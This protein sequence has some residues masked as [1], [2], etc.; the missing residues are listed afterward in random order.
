MCFENRVYQMENMRKTEESRMR[1]QKKRIAINQN[2]Q[3]CWGSRF[4]VEGKKISFEHARFTMSLSKADLRTPC[5]TQP[6]PLVIRTLR[7]EGSQQMFPASSPQFLHPP[8]F[9]FL[10]SSILELRVCT[11]ALDKA[12]PVSHRLELLKLCWVVTDSVLAGCGGQEDGCLS[13]SEGA[14]GTSFLFSLP[15]SAKFS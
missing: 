8:F 13:W 7:V 14:T 10:Q 9:H 6:D 4:C 1:N 2:G 11:S 3:D 5:S 15:T 12:L